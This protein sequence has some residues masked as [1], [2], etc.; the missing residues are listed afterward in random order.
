MRR[1][2]G[3]EDETAAMTRACLARLS[4]DPY[5]EPAI[6]AE[7]GRGVAGRVVPPH[8]VYRAGMDGCLTPHNPTSLL[9]APHRHG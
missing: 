9:S 4:I 1:S 2:R 7:V 3:W 6:T 8:A 5:R